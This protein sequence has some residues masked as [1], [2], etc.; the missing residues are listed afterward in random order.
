MELISN[1]WQVYESNG[2][3][4]GRDQTQGGDTSERAQS[5]L[6]AGNL[7][8]SWVAGSVDKQVRAV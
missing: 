3:A 4:E 7:R 5:R 2:Q 8:E 1:K 6:P